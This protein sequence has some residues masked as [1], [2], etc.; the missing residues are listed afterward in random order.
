[1]ETSAADIALW[2]AAIGGLSVLL[3]AALTAF[4]TW[5]VA[6]WST[7]EAGRVEKQ[8]E[9]DI[10]R[11]DLQRIG[12]S[13]VLEKL[14]EASKY[15]EWL[16]DGYNGLMAGS[17]RFQ[18]SERSQEYNTKMWDAWAECKSEFGKNQ[19]VFSTP[20]TTAFGECKSSL[21][22]EYESLND[23]EEELAAR[24]AKCF[25]TAHA[26]LLRIAL[27]EF[28]LNSEQEQA[29]TKSPGG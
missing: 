4:A 13:V 27:D 22:H 15:A 6:V 14:G 2:A 12:Y 18:G 19:L 16:D 17:Y 5:K 3:T 23:L 21:P 10:R 11:W 25:G 8:K 26:A 20:F 1:M 28:G 7:R 9:I 29:P 24:H